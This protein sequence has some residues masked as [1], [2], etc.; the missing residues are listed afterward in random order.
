MAK[1]DKLVGRIRYEK[2]EPDKRHFNASEWF[3]FEVKWESEDEW[4][5]ECGFPIIKVTLGDDIQDE[6]VHWSV[7]DQIKKWQTLGIP[8]HFA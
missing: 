1:K 2:R 4:R 5:Y 7:F 3:V 8:F 6:M